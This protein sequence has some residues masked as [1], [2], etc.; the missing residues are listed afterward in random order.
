VNVVEEQVELTATP[1]TIDAEEIDR[2]K[3]ELEE[4]QLQEGNVE[5]RDLSE[6]SGEWREMEMENM[7]GDYSDLNFYVI[8]GSFLVKENADR[9]Y[10]RFIDRGYQAHML[11]NPATDYYF[12]AYEGFENPEEAI[13]YTREIQNS[14]QSEAW[15]SRIIRETRLDLDR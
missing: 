13:D 12:V 15:L 6:Y 5:G 1:Q 8:G 3:A 2:L 10:D 14:V 4:R 11:F 9:L 7:N